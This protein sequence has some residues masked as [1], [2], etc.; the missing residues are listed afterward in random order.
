LDP[1]I[2]VRMSAFLSEAYIPD[3]DQRM[4]AYRRLAKMT[5][6]SEI[7]DFKSELIDRYGKPPAATN[8]LLF[9]IMLKILCNKAGIVR[10]DLA[11]HQMH[12][13]FSPA[14]IK[15]T[16]TLVEMIQAAP[17]RYA[18]TSESILKVKLAKDPGGSLKGQAKN[19]LK[20]IIERVNY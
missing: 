14:H 10:L 19:I 9:K 4:V 3:I 16:E 8:N 7:A 17:D 18:L 12:V 13:Q 11:E 20:E 1:E 15:N 2:N 6:L 5:E